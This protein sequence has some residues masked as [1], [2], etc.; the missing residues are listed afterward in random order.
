[1][2]VA[3]LQKAFPGLKI[4]EMAVG[5][6]V[7]GEGPTTFP[8]GEHETYCR[9]RIVN[10]DLNTILSAKPDSGDFSFPVLTWIR[11]LCQLHAKAPRLNWTLLLTLHGEIPWDAA[12]CASVRA[13]LAENFGLEPEFAKRCQVLLGHTLYNSIRSNT[14]V[15]FAKLTRDEQRKVLM[16]FVPKKLARIGSADGWRVDTTRNIYYGEQGEAPMV[17]WM[18]DFI[19]D[20]RIGSVPDLVY[21]ESL[22][23]VLAA[24]GQI[25]ADGTLTDLQ[26]SE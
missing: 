8:T 9:A 24:V 2:A 1:M 21:R 5:D 17:T 22:R 10:L 16:A 15:D 12:C 18:I 14:A 25:G 11:K 20:A 19:W 3:T 13:F 7:R 26:L 6:L 23:T 4:L